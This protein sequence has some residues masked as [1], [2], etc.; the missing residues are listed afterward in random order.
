MSHLF[1]LAS[2]YLYKSSKDENKK[3]ENIASKGN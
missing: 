2:P 3:E 1:A